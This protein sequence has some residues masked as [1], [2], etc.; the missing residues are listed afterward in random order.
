MSNYERYRI[1]LKDGSYEVAVAQ[2]REDAITKAIKEKH[3][4]ESKIVAV[5]KATSRGRLFKV[6]S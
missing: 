5:G 6:L 4:D 2:N 1:W 3:V